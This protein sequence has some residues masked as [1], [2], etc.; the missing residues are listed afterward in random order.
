MVELFSALRGI[1]FGGTQIWGFQKL[2]GGN[3]NTGF[4]KGYSWTVIPWLR[5]APVD[6]EGFSWK[7]VVLSAA[8]RLDV[9]A[10]EHMNGQRREDPWRHVASR[11]CIYELCSK[12]LFQKSHAQESAKQWLC[13]IQ[14]SPSPDTVTNRGPFLPK[15][16]FSGN[17]WFY[18]VSRRELE[19]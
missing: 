18:E 17:S 13:T 1:L 3:R 19:W 12:L 9:R 10:W 15:A 11:Y 4:Y 2:K 6:S 7:A 16:V 8:W 14:S 5:L